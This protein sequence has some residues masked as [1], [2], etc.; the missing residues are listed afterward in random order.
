LSLVTA[1]ILLALVFGGIAVNL[2][3]EKMKAPHVS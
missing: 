1:E 3:S 2:K